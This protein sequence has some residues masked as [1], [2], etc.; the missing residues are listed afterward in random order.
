MKEARVEKWFADAGKNLEKIQGDIDKDLK[1]QSFAFPDTI[2]VDANLDVERAVKTV[3]NVAAYLPGQTD[4][5]VIIGAHYDHLGLGEQ[6]SLAPSQTGTIHPGA[7]DNASGTA[8]VIEL[9]RCLRQ[10]AAARSAASCSSTS[11]AKSW[12]C[13]GSAYYADHPLLPLDK[14]VAMINLDMIG[15]MRDDK[16]YIGGAASGSNLK[17]MLEKLVPTSGLKVDYSGGTSEGSSD[18]TSFTVAP[19]A[20]AV[21]LLRPAR[22]LSQ[23]QRHLG[24][25]RRARRRQ[26]AGPGGRGCADAARHAGTSRVREVGRACPARRR[27]AT[28]A[29]S[30][31]TAPTSA[32]FPISAKASRA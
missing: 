14:A 15:R 3:H 25:D 16:L 12:D 8:G 30:P 23:A 20:G 17:A 32:A 18:H 9:A 13:S 4:E 11:P 19:G 5:Y 29:R 2:R 31:A 6:Y 26:T 10:T 28:P 24:Q 21:L 1:P 27:Y 7:D 22:R